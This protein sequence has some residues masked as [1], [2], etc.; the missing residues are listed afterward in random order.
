MN[1]EEYCAKLLKKVEEH[2]QMCL[3][4]CHGTPDQYQFNH[5]NLLKSIACF[6]IALYGEVNELPKD[7]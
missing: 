7:E 3:L 2:L 5:N 1:K 4:A 6:L